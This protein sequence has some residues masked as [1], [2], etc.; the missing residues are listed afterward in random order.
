MNI[1]LLYIICAII[2]VFIILYRSN[3]GEQVY[4]FISVQGSKLYS[5]V[6]PYTY[7]EIRKKIKDLNKIILYNN[8][9]VRYYFLPLVEV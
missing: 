2:L 7:K 9:L 3:T 6:A 1:T 5:R 4:Q 8:M